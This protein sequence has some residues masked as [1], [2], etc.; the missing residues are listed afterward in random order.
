MTEA[1]QGD[2]A[3]SPSAWVRDQV[4]A[5]EGSNGAEANTLQGGTDPIIV[6]TNRG[7]KSGKIRKTPLMRVEKDG[8]YLAV[9]SKGGA[10]ENPVWVNNFRAHPTMELQ[11]GAVKKTYVARELDGEERAEWWEYAVA[12]WATYGEYQKKTDRLLPL[13]LLE[14]LD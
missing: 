5:F 2:Y 11:D 14:P 9:A 6:I 8:K 1:L 13:F 12:T 4:E 7:A 3:P 10:P